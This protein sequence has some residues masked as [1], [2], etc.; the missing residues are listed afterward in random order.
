MAIGSGQKIR[1]KQDETQS[2]SAGRT[3]F[4]V[5]GKRANPAPPFACFAWRGGGVCP[6]QSDRMS[7][8]H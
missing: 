8:D 6:R 4:C 2:E 5:P 3:R 7:D 1:K